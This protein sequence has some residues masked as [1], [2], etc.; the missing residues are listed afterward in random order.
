MVMSDSELREIERKTRLLK[1]NTGDYADPGRWLLEQMPRLLDELRAYRNPSLDGL[2]ESLQPW[3]NQMAS[4]FGR[5]V[6]LVGSALRLPEPRDYD[7]RIVVT[8]EEF[9]A[10]YGDP[11]A[12]AEALWWP[13]RNDGSLR[14]AADMGDLSREA[15]LALSRNID[16]QVQP[17]CEAR[18]H[19]VGDDQRLD[20][21][22]R[23]RR[24]DTV[25]GLEDVALVRAP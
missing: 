16:F 20:V 25:P 11:Y 21:E 12:W 23:R 5:P 19:L 24:L 18:R 7:I 13:S 9:T 2:C 3:A 8:D 22:G 17:P 4:R 6:Y 1:G 14:Y 15:S 10:R